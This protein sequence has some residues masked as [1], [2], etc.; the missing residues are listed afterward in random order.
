MIR[1]MVVYHTKQDRI[2]VDLGNH[3]ERK[4]ALARM[5]DTCNTAVMNHSSPALYLSSFLEQ[6]W[7]ANLESLTTL[8]PLSQCDLSGSPA[9]SMSPPKG[10]QTALVLTEAQQAFS[11]A[12]L[13]KQDSLISTCHTRLL[14]S[15]RGS[16]IGSVICLRRPDDSRLC[17]S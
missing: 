4:L 14:N 9:S 16:G 10:W 6:Q 15:Q 12:M 2:T 11:C 7:K 5:H 1:S 13:A 8:L 17:R 3:S